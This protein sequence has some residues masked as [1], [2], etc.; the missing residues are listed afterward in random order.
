VETTPGDQ[1]HHFGC[2]TGRWSE[3]GS[4]LEIT[5]FAEKPDAAYAAEH[6]H[7][8]GMEENAYL[9][10]FG[11]YVLTPKV[12]EFLDENIR[13]NLRERGEFQLTSCLDRVRQEE[14]FAACR[15]EGQ[16]HD[17]GNPQAYMRSLCEF[18]SPNTAVAHGN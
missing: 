16:R 4:M 5:E 8:D 12:F 11:Q 17:I 18:A 7:V 6:L 9:T 13:R 15:V 2:V 1:V 3:K 10:V 14:G